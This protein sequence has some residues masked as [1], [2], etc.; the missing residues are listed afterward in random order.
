MVAGSYL[1][2]S[3]VLAVSQNCTTTKNCRADQRERQTE[4]R[5]GRKTG[6]RVL[7]LNQLDKGVFTV[8]QMD[9]LALSR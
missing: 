1:S 2:D 9:L 5:M 7:D 8:G 4:A 3:M 6:E